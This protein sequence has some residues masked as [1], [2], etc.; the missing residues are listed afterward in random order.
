MSSLGRTTEA[1]KTADDI[2]RIAELL[3]K[4]GNG[5]AIYRD[6]WEF[7]VNAALRISDLLS[8]T[9]EQALTGVVVLQEGKTKKLRTITLNSTARAVVARRAAANPHHAWLFEVESNRASGKP[10]SRVSVS[11]KFKEIGEIVGIRLASHSMRKTCLL[12]TSDAAD[13]RSSVDL[14]GR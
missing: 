6:I 3:E 13:E 11:R 14:G 10:I 1:A 8:I 4:H 9:M 2:A 5:S 7:G 12:Y